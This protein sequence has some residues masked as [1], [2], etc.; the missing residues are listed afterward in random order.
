[1]R[2]QSGSTPN[3]SASLININFLSIV[4]FLA[5]SGVHVGGVDPLVWA[6][7]RKAEYD[8]WLTVGEVHGA[9]THLLRSSGIDFLSWSVHDSLN[10]TDGAVFWSLPGKC[11][12]LTPIYKVLR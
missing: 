10:V 6:Q 3:G 2:K 11:D 8:S 9:N 5:S 7:H 4:F 12:K 1:M